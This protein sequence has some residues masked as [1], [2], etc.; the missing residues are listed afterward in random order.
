M[1]IR[2]VLMIA[3]M[4]C[5]WQTMGV[6]GVSANTEFAGYTSLYSDHKARRVGDIITII[7]A[8]SSKASKSAATKTSKKS[9]SDGTLSDLF[10]LGNLP[11]KMGVN[12]GSDYSGSGSTTRSGSMEAKISATVKDVLPNGNLVVE[13]F[14]Q[15]A[16]NDDVQILTVSG[17]VRP[18]SV[19]SDNTVLS[20]Y[21][22]DAQIKYTGEGTTATSPGIVTKIAKVIQAPFH[23]V[24]GIFRRII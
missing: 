21:L 12:A 2:V 13:G 5:L 3:V 1:G 18:E 9:G 22:A 14:R 4:V 23:W 10:G 17:V 20:I 24:A 6:A 15:V 11:V 19:S 7:I 16:V 8:E